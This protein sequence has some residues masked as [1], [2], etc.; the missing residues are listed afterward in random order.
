M[1][2]RSE[3]RAMQRPRILAGFVQGT[4]SGLEPGLRAGVHARLAPETLARLQK[5]SRLAW[6]PLE[7]DVE[8]R[9]AI[10]AELGAGRAHELFRR[11]LSAALD[12][13]IL[14]SLAQGALRLFGPSPERLFAWAPKAYAQIY[15]DAGEMRFEL[16]E[17]GSARLE[18]SSLPPAMAASRDY[19][20]GVA[21][22]IAAGF[23]LL[24]VKG[25]V[26]IERW[27]AERRAA[28]FRLQWEEDDPAE[29][30]PVPASA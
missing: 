25:E 23:D 9:H 26:G 11:N 10:Y 4:L 29:A 21:G 8:L 3:I 12:T 22:A 27:D 24:G 28:R 1:A 16:D 30:L 2:R 20:D 18:L 7:L 14:R 13:A 5:S 19:L 15:R 6:L 17:P